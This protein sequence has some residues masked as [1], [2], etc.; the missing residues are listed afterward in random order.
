M[1]NIDWSFVNENSGTEKSYL[2]FYKKIEEILDLLAP[3]RKMT[4]KEIK[5]EQMPWITRGLL[6]SMGIRDDYYKRRNNEKDPEIKAQF[7]VLYKRYRNMIVSLLRQSKGNYFASY[8]LNNQ[9]N[10]KKTWD[11]IRNLINV[12][13]K[14]NSSPSKLVYKN[15]EKVSNFDMAESLNDFFV[16]IGA[17]IEAKIPS[18]KQSFSSYLKNPNNKSIFLSP[19]TGD[20]LMSIIKDMSSSKACGPNSISTNLFN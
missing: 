3:Y 6:V 13:K 17:S 19:C 1:T 15:E 11:G 10:V 14:K 16:N 12:S 18:S 4:Q 8:F 7:T 5:L 9:S 20:E 2:Y